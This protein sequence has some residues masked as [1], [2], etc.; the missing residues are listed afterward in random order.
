MWIRTSLVAVTAAFLGCSSKSECLEKRT[1]TQGS[2]DSAKPEAGDGGALEPAATGGGRNTGG[3]GGITGGDAGSFQ[4]PDGG[5]ATAGTASGTAVGADCDDEGERAC[6]RT[7]NGSVLECTG[8]VWSLVE[9]CLR[10]TRCDS[11]DL[12]CAPIVPGC[13]RLAAGSSFCDG[14]TRI[15]CGPDLLTA[16]EEACPGKCSGGQ[17]VDPSC[18]DGIAQE[19]EACDDGNDDE[20]DTCTTACGIPK[21]GDGILSG[22]EECDDGNPSDTDGCTNDCTAAACGD[23]VLHEGEE[24]CDDG[25]DDE[26]DDCLTSCEAALCGDGVVRGSEECDDADEDD[27]DDCPT[28]CKNATCGDGFVWA[29]LETCDDANAANDDKCTDRCTAEPVALALGGDHTCVLFQDGQVK[30]WGDNRYGQIGAFADSVIGDRPG[31]LGKNVPVAITGVS[32]VT[33]GHRH[34]CALKE[35]AVL[36]WGDNTSK[37]LGPDVVGTSRSRPSVVELGGKVSS[38]CAGGTWSAALMTDQTVRIWGVHEG[39]NPD[40]ALVNFP[41]FASIKAIACGSSWLCGVDDSDRL[42]CLAPSASGVFDIAELVDRSAVTETRIDQ[43]A[44]GESAACVLAGT[45]AYCWGSNFNGQLAL[46]EPNLVQ[47]DLAQ[48]D[49]G[50]PT[51]FVATAGG[52]TCFALTNGE[53]RCWGSDLLEGALGQPEITSPYPEGRNIGGYEG[54][55]GSDLPAIKLGPDAKVRSVAT[56]GTHTC[57]LLEGSRIKCW[58][59]NSSGQLGIGT[60]EA[61]VGDEIGEMGEA[62]PFVLLE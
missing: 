42:F 41:G 14:Q 37:Q 22:D 45:S 49:P 44:V 27:A 18:G 30:C 11:T 28:N 54:D 5:K 4:A 15:T 58:G 40:G 16:E 43:L 53:V 46:L 57:A 26:T 19:G 60:T 8:G 62:L 56:N 38:V 20:D 1:C 24:E 12:Q 10:G 7:G 34:T 33:A 36:C 55:Q 3:T 21:C 39:S 35:E 23:G 6:G 61:A 17:C 51:R 59:R 2:V 52:V 13:E 50:G 47:N 9:S 29:G 32:Q 31:D 48:T 25:N